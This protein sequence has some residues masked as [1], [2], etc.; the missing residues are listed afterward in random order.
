MFK[1]ILSRLSLLFRRESVVSS[2]IIGGFA[3]CLILPQWLK[4]SFIAGSDLL[5]HYNRFYDTAMQIKTGHFSYFMSLFGFQASGR[6]VNALYGP[7]FAYFQGLLVLWSPSWLVYQLLSRWLIATVAGLSLFRLL[8]RIQLNQWP[9]LAMALVYMTTFSIQYW[10]YRQGFTSWGAAI[11]PWCLIP[12]VDYVQD[13]KIS[14]SRLALS[15]AIMTQVHLL[16]TV[17]LVLSYLP[18]YAYGFWTDRQK[19]QTIKYLLT[20]VAIFSL[21]SLN[22]FLP[23]IQVNAKNTL[24]APFVNK[25]MATNTINGGS[26]YW[27]VTPVLLVVVLILFIGWQL[28]RWQQQSALTRITFLSFLAFSFCA[29]SFF[30]WA[31]GN[32]HHIKLLETL[33]FPFRFF[34]PALVFLFLGLGLLWRNLD[35]QSKWQKLGLSLLLLTAMN[36]WVQLQVTVPMQR[37]YRNSY[38][39]IPNGKHQRVLTDA[40]GIRKAFRSQNK[41]DLLEL[42]LKST[43]DYLPQ[44]SS[45]KTQTSQK[46]AIN[47][48]DLYDEVVVKPNK[49]YQK[50]QTNQGLE[51]SWQ[52]KASGTVELPAIAYANSQLSLNGKQLTKKDYTRGLIGTIIV[53]QKEGTNRLVLSYQYPKSFVLVMIINGLTWIWLG[54]WN[55]TRH[56]NKKSLEKKTNS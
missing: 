35:K 53:H 18:F 39:T 25:T 20:S 11:L 40:V 29:T 47:Y 34:V 14:V 3:L 52:S 36:G 12:A 5:F 45:A 31:W 8:K 41:A 49:T 50:K 43:P 51:M 27:L 23:L 4:G 2:L 16:S 13:H 44:V 28:L 55:L 7:Y 54:V 6:I 33:Q 9:A 17:F 22:V 1:S 32:A 21:L 42:A 46:G 15:V 48:Y 19:G 56:F 10:T 30:P 37:G 38:N 26:S 24:L